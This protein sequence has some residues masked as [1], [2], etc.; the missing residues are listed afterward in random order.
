MASSEFLQGSQGVLLALA[1]QLLIY[2]MGW[3]V[4]GRLVPGVRGTTRHWTLFSLTGMAAMLL[5]A[6][7]GSVPDWLAVD[8]GD[9]L[10]MLT[11]TQ[12]RR[13]SESFFAQPRREREH[14]TLLAILAALLLSLRLADAPAA[15]RISGVTLLLAWVS[16]RAVLCAHGPM[17]AEFGPRLAWAL[18]GPALLFWVAV[19]GSAGWAM[20]LQHAPSPDSF[21]VPLVLAILVVA[22]ALHLSYAGMLVLRLVRQLRHLS[23][24]DPLTGLL[25]RRAMDEQMARCWRSLTREP[26]A[27]SLLA[28]DIDH[29][30]HI[31]D[32]HGHAAGDAVLVALALCLRET[33]RPHDELART[34]GEEF[35]VLLPGT[36]GQEARAVAQ[37][38][39]ERI[40]ALKL[41]LPD[42]SELCFTASLGVASQTAAAPRSS[43][44]LWSSAD[45]AL[46]QAKQQGRNRVVVSA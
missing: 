16:L 18:H 5:I 23:R 28:L 9:L 35:L 46:Y 43:V 36:G 31:N 24:H 20:V 27:M 21:S 8:G 44:A 12:M 29:F 15:L 11:L 1:L 32:S 38:L 30:K 2:G 10:M 19:L 25:N 22:A 26:Q 33:L 37:R 17:R 14:L 7:R 42:G 45:A 4:A 39:C 3:T 41:P 40:A 34:G 6:S 13:G